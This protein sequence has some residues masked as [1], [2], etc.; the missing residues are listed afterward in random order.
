MTHRTLNASRIGIALFMAWAASLVVVG[1]ELVSKDGR[2]LDA[3]ILSVTEDK[4]SFQRQGSEKVYQIPLTDL[5]D[6]TVKRLKAWKPSPSDEDATPALIEAMKKALPSFEITFEA[7]KN[8]RAAEPRKE[9]NRRESISPIVTI[10][11]TDRKKRTLENLKMTAVTFS[12]GVVEK[13]TIKVLKTDTFDVSVIAGTSRTYKCSGTSYVFDKASKKKHGYKYQ[14]YA[15]VLHDKEGNVL[16]SKSSPEGYA[17]IP[18][19]V[20]KVKAGGSYDSN[21]EPR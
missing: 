3:K 6:E 8:N 16:F 12:R 1:E 13:R 2:K 4:V 5:N 18:E 14:G 9:R 21:L 11:N 10:E 19:K 20:L 17:K 7:K 15:V